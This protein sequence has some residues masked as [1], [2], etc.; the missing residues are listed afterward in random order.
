M[1]IINIENNM[2]DVFVS[3]IIPMYNSEQYISDCL[4]TCINQTHS[5]IEI[6]VVDDGST[7]RSLRIVKEYQ[8]KDER[9]HI[10]SQSNKGLVESRKVGVKNALYDLIVFLDSDDELEDDAVSILVQQYIE[11]KADLILA[12]FWVE[13]EKKKLIFKQYNTYKYGLSS[14]GVL[15]SIL[16]KDAAPTIWGKL[17]RKDVFLRT[18]TPSEITIGEDAVTLLQILTDKSLMISYVDNCIYHYIQRPFSMINKKNKSIIDK[19]LKLLE[20]VHSYYSKN[21]E[22]THRYGEYYYFFLLNEYFSLLKDG[23][24]YADIQCVI[25]SIKP[26]LSF[27]RLKIIKRMGLVR[28]CL[29]YTSM[30]SFLIFSVLM[31][32]YLFI[33]KLIYKI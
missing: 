25:N 10:I 33:R 29:I 21:L 20:W 23:A 12:N 11:T 28:W 15:K 27:Y 30:N 3:V 16:I 22:S 4:D 13:T 26:E 5:A 1:G 6:L 31:N 24:E 7:D 9:I 19:R 18:N 14:E 32:S 2:A 17:I 8:C